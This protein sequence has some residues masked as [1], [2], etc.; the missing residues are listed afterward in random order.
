MKERLLTVLL[1]MYCPFCAAQHKAEYVKVDSAPVVL[2]VP[3]FFSYAPSYKRDTVFT[4]E[5]F[6]ENDSLIQE[7]KD[8][9]QVKYV[10]QMK[11]FTDSNHTYRDD[12]G[13]YK[14]LPVSTI[15]VRYDRQGEHN[16]L[17]VNY[18]TNKYTELIEA[19]D[20]IVK[21]DTI[22]SVNAITHSPEQAVIVNYY[23][24]QKVK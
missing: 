6:D 8:F 3:E 7:V 4:F 5:C 11:S 19:T 22:N 12:D 9:T 1:I 21:T 10:S 14:P 2:L 17:S 16:W 13:K 18:A 15:M 23:K 20:D 24:V